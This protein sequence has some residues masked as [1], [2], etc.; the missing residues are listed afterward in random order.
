MCVNCVTYQGLRIIA[1]D[2]VS[3]Y[4]SFMPRVTVSSRRGFKRTEKEAAASKSARTYDLICQSAREFLWSHPVRDLSVAKLMTLAGASRPTFYQ[5][6]ADLNEMLEVMLREIQS[7]IMQTADHWFQSEGDHI[8]RLE[9]TLQRMIDTSYKHGTII[10][11]VSDAA[12]TDQRME[13]DWH[14]FIESFA[15]V[16]A[17]RIEQDQLSGLTA[18]FPALPTAMA[19]TRLNATTMIETFGHRPRGNRE[20]VYQTLRRIWVSTL[21]GQAGLSQMSEQTAWSARKIVSVND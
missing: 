21:Y 7:E 1:S 19:L 9:L 3:D 13:Q 14:R 6:F 4:G 11:A 12:P 18:A 8:Y 10:R 16:T 5:Y 20:D 2:R 15:R 17:E